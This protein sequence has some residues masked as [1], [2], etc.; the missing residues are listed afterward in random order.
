[1]KTITIFKFQS[2]INMMQG[3]DPHS[4]MRGALGIPGGKP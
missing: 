1:M 4:A 3:Y 2:L